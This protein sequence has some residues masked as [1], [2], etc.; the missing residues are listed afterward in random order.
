MHADIQ[1]TLGTPLLTD[2][3]DGDL[4]DELSELLLNDIPAA[5]PGRPSPYS[6]KSSTSIHGKIYSIKANS[7]LKCCDSFIFKTENS[8]Y[9]FTSS[10]EGSS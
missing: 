6:D 5:P 9:R 2:T 1:V 7:T 4:E 10:T 3:N 8:S